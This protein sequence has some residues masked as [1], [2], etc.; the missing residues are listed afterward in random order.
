[1]GFAQLAHAA[2]D[3]SCQGLVQYLW[4]F[5]PAISSTGSDPTWMGLSE[6]NTKL[7]KGAHHLAAPGSVEKDSAYPFPSVPSVVA[8]SL[9]KDTYGRV[10]GL[11]DRYVL[12]DRSIEDMWK[13]KYASDTSASSMQKFATERANILGEMSRVAKTAKDEVVRYSLRTKNC[14]DSYEAY[15]TAQNK[16]VQQQLDNAVATLR[17]N[18]EI[19]AHSENGA[20]SA[21]SVASQSD[22]TPTTAVPSVQV[23]TVGG[24]RAPASLPAITPEDKYSR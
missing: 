16:Q 1:M 5:Q 10:K 4:N 11:Y 3:D 7:H 21:E 6:M 18:E 19:W 23:E 20:G 24:S 14:F 8:E 2:D 13:D 9:D 22:F 17:T 12:L 15:V